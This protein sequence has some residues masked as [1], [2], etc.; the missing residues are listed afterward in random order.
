MN[1]LNAF[2]RSFRIRVPLII[3]SSILIMLLMEALINQKAAMDTQLANLR[4]KLES[5]AATSV[6]LVNPMDVESV[7]LNK[8]GVSA[9][10]YRRLI[11]VFK[12]IESQNPP[13]SDVY[14]LVKTPKKDQ[15]RFVA[16]YEIPSHEW[17]EPSAK[18]GDPY[19]ASSFPEM[20]E[21][22]KQPSA[23][24]D[25]GSDDW[26]QEISGY[27]PIRD[28]HGRTAAVLGED[29]MASDVYQLRSE[30]FKNN[31]IIFL[32]GV[33]LAIILGAYLAH[34]ITGP[35][36]ELIEGTKRISLGDLNHKV[37][38]HG[39]DEL[40]SL[41]AAFN[42]MADQLGE[43]LKVNR[44]YFYGVIESMVK[45]VEAKD[46]YT[47]GH[48]ERVARYATMIARQMGM[49]AK[50]IEG[51]HQA[52]LLHDIGKMAIRDELLH[53]NGKLTDDEWKQVKGHPVVGEEILKPVVLNKD[54]L[55]IV[56]W[57]HERLDGLGYP[58]RLQGKDIPLIVQMVSVADSFD[59]MTSLRPYRQPMNKEVAIAE[60]IKN[61][62]TQ[63]DPKVVDAFVAALKQ[64][65]A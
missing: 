7:P 41:G 54:M 50:T 1:K 59:A 58:D 9:P 27:A 39:E 48:S 56:R 47:R 43:S 22:F 44:Q 14:V 32:I 10:A 19:D 13:I 64:Q 37:A 20:M 63:F 38:V 61:K 25:I 60:L 49:D 21:G 18:P 28:A 65:G 53:K 4:D 3:I 55:A 51:V 35:V 34:G 62:G 30:L 11:Q 42:K 31:L 5:V 57:H 23:D 29:M 8:K 40:S 12:W 17:K 46:P 36:E 45:I 33:I 52:A 24:K 15:L 16:D 26:G 6:L 2:L